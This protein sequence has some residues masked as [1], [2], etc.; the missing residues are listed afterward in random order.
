MFCGLFYTYNTMLMVFL[1]FESIW[2][3][4]ATYKVRS[5]SCQKFQIL[6]C[7]ILKKKQRPVSDAEC[8][9]ESNDAICFFFCTWSRTPKITFD[10]MASPLGVM[11]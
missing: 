8:P 11:L 10:C 4:L 9:Q 7:S 5:R 1:Q 2:V 6:K 3:S